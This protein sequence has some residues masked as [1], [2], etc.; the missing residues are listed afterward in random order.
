MNS[1]NPATG[2]ALA[3]ALSLTSLTAHADVILTYTGKDFTS[4]S[5]GYTTNDKVTV[6]ITLKNPLGDDQNDQFITPE[7]FSISD[8]MQTFTNMTSGISDL[9]EFSTDST[10]QI[11]AWLVNAGPEPGTFIETQNLSGETPLDETVI[12]AFQLGVSN[13]PGTW[14]SAVTVP[15]PPPSNLAAVG[16][17]GLAF[18]WRRRRQISAWLAKSANP[19]RHPR[20]EPVT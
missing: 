8:G 9:F 17:L 2:A 15:G 12:G 1:K 14:T 11:T 3:L 13:S 16:V 7:T 19:H 10:G 20:I 5:G 6:N 4:V 18:F